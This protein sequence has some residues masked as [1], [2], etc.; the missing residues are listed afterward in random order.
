MSVAAV[1]I[2]WLASFS[3]GAADSTPPSTHL[4]T[5]GAKRE[6]TV[7]LK[8]ARIVSLAPS[9]TEL[10][11]AVGAGDLVVGVTAFCDYPPE[12]ATRTRIGG[13]IN[14]DIE[15]IVSLRPDL[16][17]A[18]TAGNYLDDT[19]RIERLG[20]PVYTVDTPSVEAILKALLT[21][22]ALVGRADRAGLI[23]AELIA[24]IEK[25]KSSHSG[26]EHPRVLFVIEPEPLI[27][28]GT[29]TFIGEAISL[30]GAEVAAIDSE[31]SWAQ[32]DMEQVIG[33]RPDVILT[34]EVNRIWA[35]T[36]GSMNE[37]RV[38]P[39]V[40]KKQVFVVSDS[41]QHPGPRLVD[42]IEEIAAILAELEGQK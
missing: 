39:A 24:R 21:V 28:P 2:F 22:G 34:T 41:I 9:V 16:V 11:F 38:V 32:Y 35:E 3:N 20:V 40:R 17:L 6:V 1:L 13:L 42:G 8:P 12:A 14:P 4:V 19:E 5:D 10:L 25:I 37:W 18:S 15:K 31:V 23:N 30:A 36:V 33:L 7:P 26:S 27:A 29:N